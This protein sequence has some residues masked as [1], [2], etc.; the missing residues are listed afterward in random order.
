M[1]SAKLFETYV[2]TVSCN[3]GRFSSH[4]ININCSVTSSGSVLLF[5]FCVL[6]CSLFSYCTVSACNVRAANLTE[7][8]QYFFLSCKANSRVRLAKT[9]HGPHFPNWLIYYCYVCLI[10]GLLHMFH[11]VYCLCVN[12]SCNAATG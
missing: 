2:S 7:V 8:F 1:S 3:T 9:G 5:L 11:S 12:V 4:K 10:F 6:Y